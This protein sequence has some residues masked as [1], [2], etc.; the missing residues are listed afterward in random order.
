VHPSNAHTASRASGGAA[1]SGA[2]AAVARA[3]NGNTQNA[4]DADTDNE[5]REVRNINFRQYEVF[6]ARRVQAKTYASA[7]AE[8]FLIVGLRRDL[9]DV[10]IAINELVGPGTEIHLFNGFG[11]D[12]RLASLEE[13]SEFG[14]SS[15]SN[16]HLV[17][18]VGNPVSRADLERL[19]RTLD[20]MSFSTIFITAGEKNEADAHM[21]DSKNIATLLLI[22]A[23]QSGTDSDELPS[24]ENVALLPSTDTRDPKLHSKTRMKVRLCV[25]DRILHAVSLFGTCIAYRYAQAAPEREREKERERESARLNC[26]SCCYLLIAC[27]FVIDKPLVFNCYCREC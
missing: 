17:H 18:H 12:E 2:R 26:F 24:L 22:R 23:I 9:R 20:F 25:R 27:G 5:M 19:H 13:N 16:I 6:C 11:I 7:K 1:R 15:L 8:K 4:D 3:A 21:S 14:L 10:L